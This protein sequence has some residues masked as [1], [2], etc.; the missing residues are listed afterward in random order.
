MISLFIS[1]HVSWFIWSFKCWLMK[2][3]EDLILVKELKWRYLSLSPLGGNKVPSTIIILPE[4]KKIED[5]IVHPL[6]LHRLKTQTPFFLSRRRCHKSNMRTNH[7]SPLSH[8]EDRLPLPCKNESLLPLPLSAT[9]V[10]NTCLCCKN[11]ATSATVSTLYATNGSV[12][13]KVGTAPASAT[14]QQKQ[15]WYNLLPRSPRC[16]ARETT[17]TG[18]LLF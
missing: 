16:I 11:E 9:N 10:S 6:I 2:L 13:S 14:N 18:T 3:L 17:I 15:L 1:V 7:N 5:L 4:G 8:W 12:T